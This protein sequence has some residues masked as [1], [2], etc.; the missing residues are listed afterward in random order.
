MVGTVYIV[1]PSIQSPTIYCSINTICAIDVGLYTTGD[2]VC[3]DAEF[4]FYFSMNGTQQS[5]YDYA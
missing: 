4:E 5:S 2:T 1:P 3:S